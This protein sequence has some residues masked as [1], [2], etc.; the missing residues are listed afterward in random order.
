MDAVTPNDPGDGD[1]GPNNLQNFPV[2]TSVSS[3]SGDTTVEGMLNSAP[4]ATYRIEF[5]SNSTCDSSG[6]GEGKTFLGSA[7]V[8]TDAGGNANF[9]VM[10]PGPL[11]LG[12]AVTATASDAGNNTSEFAACT[13]ACGNGISDFGEQCDDGNNHD[14][15][16]CKNDCTPNVCGDGS[17]HSGVEECDDGNLIDGDGCDSHCVLEPKTVTDTVGPGGTVTTDTQSAGATPSEPVQAGVT[18][19]TGGTIT[20]TRS[21]GITG[22][23]GFMVLTGTIHIDAPPA[24]SPS[25][26]LV[27][28]FDIDA[29]LIPPDEDQNTVDIL[30]DGVS[31]PDCTGSPGEASPDPCVS[32]RTLL[33]GGDIEL[34]VVTTTASDWQLAVSACGA[35]PDAG[36]APSASGKGR[37]Q[38]KN[39]TPDTGDQLKWKWTGSMIAPG[40][41]GSPTTASNYIMCLYDQNSFKMIAIAAAGGTCGTKSCWRASGGG[42]KYG[43]KIGAGYG[44]RKI[45]LKPGEAGKA[46]ISVAGRGANLQIPTLQLST[47]VRVQLK[48][49]DG[50]P[51]WEATYSRA[52]TNT[53]SEFK[54]KS[55]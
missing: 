34:T 38:M 31:V 14:M 28:T 40:D 47:P 8:T 17:V 45:T 2:L 12:Y 25:D 15:D 30:K 37:L 5:F 49:S 4:T 33:V 43:D 6:N 19:P 46:K 1:E 41:L 27:L 24:S 13:R 23:P 11:P 54:A 20:I 16:A 42:F 35:T 44:L 29:S 26:P 22:E 7:D 55:D 3:T 50:S 21:S 51:C 48:R 36:C 53:A 9:T 39:A 10:F 18:S 52:I 32:M